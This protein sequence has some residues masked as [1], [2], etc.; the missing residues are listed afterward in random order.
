LATG[1]GLPQDICAGLCAGLSEARRVMCDRQGSWH[2]QVIAEDGETAANPN[3]QNEAR[4]HDI[5][6]STAD[7]IWEVDHQGRFSF[8]AGQIEE[9]LGYRP[10]ELLGKTPFEIMEAAEAERIQPLFERARDARQPLGKQKNW[11]LGKDGRRRCFAFTGVPIF[12]DCDVLIGYCGLNRDITEQ[13]QNEEALRQSEQR[14]LLATE[15]G[16][17]GIWDWK[18]HTSFLSWNTQMYRLYGLPP[19]DGQEPYAR[20]LLALHPDDR[21]RMEREVKHALETPTELNSIFR[22]LIG[23]E[24]RWLRVAARLLANSAGQPTVMIGCNWDVTESHRVQER[25]ARN[26]AQF[27]GAFEIAPNGMAL[28]DNQGRWMQ[29]NQALCDILG[30][31][32]TELLALNFQSISHPDDLAA[33]LVYLQRLI[34]G[35]VDQVHIDKRYLH[36]DGHSIPVLVSASAVRDGRGR[37]SFMVAHVLDLTE[38]RASEAAMLA[39]KEAAEAANRAK[40]EFLA[41]MS[42]EIRTPLNAMIGLTE[43]T[44]NTQLDAQQRDYLDKVRQSSRALLGVLNDILDYSK[45]EAG[46]VILEQTQFR[47]EDLLEQLTA[48]FQ[49]AAESKGLELLYHLAPDVPRQLIGDPMRLGQ[50]LNNLIGNAVKFTD[51]GYIKLSIWV[52]CER[53]ERIELGFSVHDTGIGM[54]SN[55]AENLFQAFTQAD[56][57]IT[58]RYGGTGL[59]LTISQQLI[60]LMGGKIQV[61][62][63]PGQGSTFRFHV[64]FNLIDPTSARIGA[65]PCELHHSRVLIVAQRP[66]ARQLIGEILCSWRM[67]VL[68]AD[69]CPGARQV[70]FE[71]AAASEPVDLVLMEAKQ[72]L[73]CSFCPEASMPINGL[74]PR[75]F[76]DPPTPVVLMVTSLEQTQLLA[77]ANASRLPRLLLKP[78]TPS[79][80]FDTMASMIQIRPSGPAPGLAPVPENDRQ[81][82]RGLQGVRVLV[83]EDHHI[84]QVVVEGI[85]TRAGASVTMAQNG[86]EAVDLALERDF[87]AVLMDLQMPVLDGLEA[88]AAIRAHKPKLPIIALTAAALAE[89]RARCFAVGMNDHLGKPIVPA[90]LVET[91]RRWVDPATHQGRMPMED[92]APASG[93]APE[94]LNQLRQLI[95]D[96]D[97]VPAELLSDLRRDASA[98]QRQALADI[99]QA[100]AL[101]DY[102]K[103]AALLTTLPSGPNTP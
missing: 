69:N 77:R 84:N 12:D 26:E 10:Q 7:F 31:S 92:Q 16:G 90:R 75:A 37:L 50:V 6:S 94:R 71:A 17:I 53:A 80:L 66:A 3:L 82:S 97:Y 55:T 98:D 58:R 43:L 85:L 46:R 70:V 93:L 5:L 30:Y 91:L 79:A 28:V 40:S 47:L 19:G 88:T 48:L 60:H 86:R 9:L 45:I 81:E 87:D 101:F 89:D 25:M 32:A 63:A 100:L 22:I 78:I 44:L 13:Q 41:N 99:E 54:D 102:D 61:R 20:W 73:D 35:E 103:A 56:G 42:H 68:E 95:A 24:I 34:D 29:V 38:R 8:V 51:N 76:G 27:R 14:L 18:I 15:A 36:K 33:D 57:S 67:S 72:C 21:P 96:N 62:T 23:Q 49:T 1:F 11:L 59:G 2:A 65:P 74:P 52:V 83:A 64:W 39:A 4:L